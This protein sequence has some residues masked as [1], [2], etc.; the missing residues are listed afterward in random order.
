[1]DSQ[2]KR[3]G[4]ADFHANKVEIDGDVVGRDKL[5]QQ[6]TSHNYYGAL[7]AQPRRAELPHQ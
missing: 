4:G 6:T 5:V 2:T 7:P 1:M 3:S